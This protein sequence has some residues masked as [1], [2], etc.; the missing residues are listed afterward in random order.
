MPFNAIMYDLDGLLIDSEKY[1][2]K[3]WEDFLRERNIPFTEKTHHAFMGRSLRE[4][5]AWAKKEFNLIESTA[6]LTKIFVE[7][8][9][10]VYNHL[11]LPMPGAARLIRETRACYK[12]QVI[13]SGSL[14]SHIS[15]VVERLGWGAWFD[16][17]FS[18]ED[19]GGVGK[20]NP[21]VYLLAAEK[22]RVAPTDCVALEDSENGLR[23]AK[24]AGMSCV[25]VPDLQRHEGDFSSANLIVHSLDDE[26]VIAYLGIR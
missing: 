20:P 4:N 2:G 7:K 12:T 18:V 26:E 8:T 25:A 16:D 23:A 3:C 6:T 10:A 5:I 15:M 19:V 24:A 17:Y 22:C 14:R 11:A 13:V 21:A 9:D 1:W